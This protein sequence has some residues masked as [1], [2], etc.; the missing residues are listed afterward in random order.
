MH[1]KTLI[2][3]EFEA[4]RRHE[5][6]PMRGYP[7]LVELSPENVAKAEANIRNDSAYIK[8][9]DEN[10]APNKK[11]G[12][13]TAYWMMKLKSVLIDGK[14]VSPQTYREYLSETVV[15]IDRDNSTHLNCDGGGR[16][17]MTRRLLEFPDKE[18]N[19]ITRRMRLVEALRNPRATKY[20]LIETLSE[21]TIA[22]GENHNPRVNLSFASKFCHYACFYFFEGMEEQD[23]Y[24]IYDSVVSKV[25]PLYCSHFNIP[26]LRCGNKDYVLYQETIDAIIKASASDDKSG[27]PISRNGFDHLLWYYFKGRQAMVDEEL[28]NLRSQPR[29][30]RGRLKGAMK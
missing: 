12:G 15:A 21:R 14:D 25:L 16:E 9:S 22:K 10:A 28:R 7:K 1:K 29:N 6:R 5:F 30:E 11:Y 2:Q 20:S 17:E 13:S 23:N 26:K 24:S 19:E 4:S 8:S 18:L 27:K 3:R